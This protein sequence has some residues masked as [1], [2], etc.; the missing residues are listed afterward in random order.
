MHAKYSIEYFMMIFSLLIAI[1]KSIP[2]LVIGVLPYAMVLGGFALFLFWNGGVV[3]G[4][5]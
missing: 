2:R 3:L 1:P 4:M 5:V